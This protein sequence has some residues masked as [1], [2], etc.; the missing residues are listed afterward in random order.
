M[1]VGL[2]LKYDR[3]IGKWSENR[4]IP[5]L[6]GRVDRYANL[7]IKIDDCQKCTVNKSGAFNHRIEPDQTKLPDR[8]LFF[9][10]DLLFIFIFP[11]CL[12]F[13]FSF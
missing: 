7:R 1:R 3:E 12:H 4:E 9:Y 13:F 6:W 11:S 10:F 8:T 5:D 2:F